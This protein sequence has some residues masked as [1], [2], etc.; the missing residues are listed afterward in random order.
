MPPS[1]HIFDIL[2]SRY[3]YQKL[4]Y[5]IEERPGPDLRKGK[6]VFSPIY[7]LFLFRKLNLFLGLGEKRREEGKGRKM[8]DLPRLWYLSR[9]VRSLVLGWFIHI[10]KL[11]QFDGFRI[12]YMITSE[13]LM[14]LVESLFGW[15]IE[16][17]LML[18]CNL[19][20]LVILRV[21]EKNYWGLEDLR[22]ENE[23]RSSLATPGQHQGLLPICAR[24]WGSMP[25]VCQDDAAHPERAQIGHF[26]HFS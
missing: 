7:F 3:V 24:G 23:E 22:S 19:F 14:N 2:W 8:K 13:L 5:W 12:V 25:A 16:C 21:W 20:V 6:L 15:V 1:L 26:A 4:G 9:Y 11:F 10:Q 17:P 18:I